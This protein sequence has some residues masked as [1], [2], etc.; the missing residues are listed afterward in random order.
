MT[1]NPP[2]INSTSPLPA[3]P[4][5]AVPGHEPFTEGMD[6]ATCGQKISSCPYHGRGEEQDRADWLEGFESMTDQE[7]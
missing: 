5:F 3:R 2:R 1:M 4:A 6:A 7:P